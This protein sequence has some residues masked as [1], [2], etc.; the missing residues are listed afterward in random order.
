MSKTTAIEG[1]WMASGLRV[2]AASP[3]RANQSRCLLS[4]AAALDGMN[5]TD[6]ARMGGMD[7]QTLR[8]W[9]YRFNDSGPEG[10]KD[11][12]QHVSPGG[13]PRCR[14]GNLRR[15]SKRVLTVRPMAWCV[16]GGST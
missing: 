13:R 8:D 7:R 11:D 10:L 16:G 9:V 12:W 2:L 1:D 3:K 4:L 15:S 5:R 6:A 14:W